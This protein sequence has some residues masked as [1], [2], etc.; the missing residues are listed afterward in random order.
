MIT[1]FPDGIKNLGLSSNDSLYAEKNKQRM[2]SFL[3]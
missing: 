1:G 3:I 2:L